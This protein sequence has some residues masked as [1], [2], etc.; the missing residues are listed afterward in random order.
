MFDSVIWLWRGRNFSIFTVLGDSDFRHLAVA[1]ESEFLTYSLQWTF[2]NSSE[3]NTHVLEDGSQLYLSEPAIL[4]KLWCPIPHI[5]VENA[6]GQ[7]QGPGGHHRGFVL[8][9]AML[10]QRQLNEVLSQV[11]E[12]GFGLR[13]LAESLK[14]S[15]GGRYR[16]AELKRDQNWALHL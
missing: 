3:E 12:L 11:E 1:N 2:T 7:V 6:D 9:H 5:T 14:E 15:I 16:Y 10:H 8:K 4:L 13:D